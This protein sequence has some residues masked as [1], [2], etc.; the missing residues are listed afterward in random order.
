MTT[1]VFAPITRTLRQRVVLPSLL[2]AAGAFPFTARAAEPEVYAVPPAPTDL[3]P[4]PPPPPVEDRRPQPAAAPPVDGQWVH[5]NQYGWVW[6]PYDR[7]YTYVPDD[8]EPSMYV[9]GPVIGWRWVTAPWVFGWG[10]DPYWGVRGRAYFAWHTRPWFVRR[11]YRPVVVHRHRPVVVHD[12]RRAV[13]RERR[14][15]RVH[16]HRHVYR[17]EPRRDYRPEYRR[18]A[19][20]E[21]RREYRP[22]YRRDDRREVR[23]RERREVRVRERGDRGR[24]HRHR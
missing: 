10:P 6:M 5:T 15:V 9:Y 1:L 23:A 20:S 24:S 2:V 14:P 19:R 4:A 11:E 12:H 22:S 7:V 13:V 3:P 16:E 17:P 21:H 18:D 8:G